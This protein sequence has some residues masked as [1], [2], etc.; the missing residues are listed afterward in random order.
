[1]AGA[2]VKVAVRVRPFSSR[3]ISRDAKCVIQMQ[4]KTTCK[5]PWEGGAGSGWSWGFTNPLAQ[6]WE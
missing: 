5:Y 3:E 6:G 4:G 2:S 1:M